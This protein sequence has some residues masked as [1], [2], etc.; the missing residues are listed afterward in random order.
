MQFARV[1][2]AAD[3][4]YCYPILEANKRSSDGDPSQRTPPRQTFVPPQAN[5]ELNTFFPFD[6]YKLPKSSRYIDGVYREWSA[7]AI[8]DDD[9]EDDEDED[10]ED[11]G[12]ESAR[13]GV[14]IARAAPPNPPADTLGASFEAMSISPVRPQ[15]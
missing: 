11:E 12:V 10:D 6:P 1:A 5:T 2:H 14:S 15:G 4:V 3:F 7:V 13:I 9:D 8:D